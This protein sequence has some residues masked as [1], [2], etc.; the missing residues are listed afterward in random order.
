M[1]FIPAV[2][3]LSAF[4]LAACASNSSPDSDHAAVSGDATSET[5]LAC[6]KTV[7][8]SNLP[9][10]LCDTPAANDLTLEEWLDTT[11][12]DAVVGQGAG[13]PE[14]C[15]RIGRNVNIQRFIP[16][17][18]GGPYQ[19]RAI[20]VVAT[21]DMTV[22]G[23]VSVAAFESNDGSMF[24]DES[25]P[26]APDPRGA[27]GSAGGGGH[28]TAG[29]GSNGGP[30]YGSDT[31]IPLVGGS[32]GGSTYIGVPGGTGGGGG[33][34]VQLVACHRLTVTANATIDAGGG[35]GQ[36]GGFGTPPELS[37]GAGGGGGSG[38]TI[39]LEAARMNIKGALG[40]N[41][42]GGG[43]GGGSSSP[44]T[45]ICDS[46]GPGTRGTVTTSPASGGSPAGGG[47]G[48]QGGTGTSPPAAGSPSQCDLSRPAGPGGGGG[49][50]GRIRLNVLAGTQP[51]IAGAVFSPG[52]SI[53]TVATH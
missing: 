22:D 4:T 45:G 47:G 25:G 20:A 17:S 13:A 33:G 44:P 9:A 11:K 29:G 2:F 40:A 49:A 26:G 48:G 24:Y 39:L 14:I 41:G 30:A 53:G 12:C 6:S 37:G 32:R 52:P 21:N 36:A 51:D 43:G 18:P 8:P 5:E 35:G 1:R 19:A 3:A 23:P 10:N 34:A 38:G 46:G 50:V 27:G 16:L 28:V 42:G 31:A 7:V 15:V